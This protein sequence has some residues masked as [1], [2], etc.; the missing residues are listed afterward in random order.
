MD[1]LLASE[2]LA[3]SQL[4]ISMKHSCLSIGKY[5]RSMGQEAVIVSLK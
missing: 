3:Y 2:L 1:Y 4:S 5:W